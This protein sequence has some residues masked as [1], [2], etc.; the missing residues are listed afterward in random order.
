MS[1]ASLA[2]LAEDSKF[3][4]PRAYLFVHLCKSTPCFRRERCLKETEG[5]F[6]PAVTSLFIRSK[7]VANSEKA[8]EQVDMMV[9]VMKRAFKENLERCV[10]NELIW[11]LLF[12][13]E[14]QSL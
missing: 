5:F 1:P 2:P 10:K 11:V 12:L 9:D 8:V 13:R 6:A 4:Q 7:G 14:N 3:M